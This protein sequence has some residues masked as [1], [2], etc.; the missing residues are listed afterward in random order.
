MPDAEV[1]EDGAMIEC[2]KGNTYT[3]DADNEQWIGFEGE[4][5][6]PLEDIPQPVT[7][8]YILNEAEWREYQ[9]LKEFAL[10]ISGADITRRAAQALG[11]LRYSPFG[12]QENII[13]EADAE[14]L[15]RESDI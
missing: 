4:W 3:Y 12:R 1:Y 15:G 6:G 9:E 5:A 10:W 2:G 7:R 11:S 13:T 8:I 14:L